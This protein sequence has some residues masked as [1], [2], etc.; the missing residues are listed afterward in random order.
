MRQGE[1]IFRT[2]LVQVLII[3]TH[4]YSSI[5]LWYQY[6]ISKPFYVVNHFKE[7][8]LLLFF[9]FF[10]NQECPFRSQP[11]PFLFDWHNIRIGR[12]LMFYNLTI[13][14]RHILTA[15][16]KYSTSPHSLRPSAHSSTSPPPPSTPPSTSS[17]AAC[18][19]PHP[20]HSTASSSYPSP[21]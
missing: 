11:S 13:Y 4:S 12:D 1:I 18:H 3:N 5:L 16:S 8:Y 20:R 14:P 17:A 15:P 10:L 19:L 7:S 21:R 2:D 9:N 6:Y